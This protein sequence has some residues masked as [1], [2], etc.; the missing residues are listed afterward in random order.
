MGQ[1][2]VKRAVTYFEH[3]DICYYLE[4][5]DGIFFKDNC[6]DFISEAAVKMSKIYPD[7]FEKDNPIPQWFIDIINENIGQDIDFDNINKISFISIR[8]PFDK[9]FEY[10]KNDYEVHHSTVFQYGPNSG[11]LGIKGV[12]KYT[13]VKRVLDHL[14]EKAYKSFAFGDG[15]NDVDMFNAVDFAVAM[16]NA[17]S[18]LKDVADA[19]TDIAE[20]DGVYKAFEKLN[21]I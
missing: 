14:E 21:L 15:L 13:A 19:I 10:F 17:K 11:E 16:E 4:S 12:T 20:N 9:S 2:D 6:A 8:H 18:G 7:R 3:H 5:N 1:E